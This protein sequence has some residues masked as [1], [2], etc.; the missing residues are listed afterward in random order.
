MDEG[1]LRNMMYTALRTE[2]PF[3][4]RYPRGCGAGRSVARPAFRGAARGARTLPAR[5]A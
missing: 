3:M 1:E 2:G 4:L 5:G